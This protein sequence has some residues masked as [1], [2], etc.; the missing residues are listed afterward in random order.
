MLLDIKERYSMV[1][2]PRRHQLKSQYTA[3]RQKGITVVAYYNKFIALWDALHGI[4]D[5]TCGCNC[6]V[7][8]KIRELADIEKTHD[9]L[10]GLDDDDYGAT[11]GQILNMEPLPTLNKEFSLITQQESHK[12]IVRGHDDKSDIVFFA[13]QSTAPHTMERESKIASDSSVVSCT[14][15]GRDGHTYDECYHR[16]GFPNRGRGRGRGNNQ[17]GRGRG[18]G[19]AGQEQTHATANATQASRNIETAATDS[20]FPTHHNS[21]IEQ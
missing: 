12:N 17:G 1:N 18:R 20:C 2:G 3:L 4:V 11:R 15:C 7:A 5:M 21:W 13:V 8:P 10:T 9:F 16:I 6:S 14:Y 19:S